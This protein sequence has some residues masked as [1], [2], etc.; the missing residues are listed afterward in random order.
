MMDK[1]VNLLNIKSDKMND[2]DKSRQT[3]KK[4]N[5]NIRKKLYAAMSMLLVCAILLT[6]ATYAWLSLSVAPS[7][8]K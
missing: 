4:E 8:E 5:R 2:K 6:T 3:M 1:Y 7:V